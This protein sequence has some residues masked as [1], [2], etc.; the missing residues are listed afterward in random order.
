MNLFSKKAGK[1]FQCT[2]T[3]ETVLEKEVGSIILVAL[4]AHHTPN[5]SSCN[6]TYAM[7]AERYL[8]F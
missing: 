1:F 5:S 4:L 3:N 6:G 8:L 7:S 2:F